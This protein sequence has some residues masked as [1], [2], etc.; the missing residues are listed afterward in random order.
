MSDGTIFKFNLGNNLKDAVTGYQ[1]I[2]TARHEYLN[3][4]IRYTLARPLDKDGKVQED[5]WFDEAVL[6]FVD[7]G[8]K[9]KKKDVGGPQTSQPP[10]QKL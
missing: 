9:I 10:R 7:E 3:G 8:L 4:C 6:S 1:G 5:H 2:C